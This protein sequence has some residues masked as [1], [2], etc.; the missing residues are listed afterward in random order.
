MY[1]WGF[2]VVSESCLF[3]IK[4]N[5]PVL[6]VQKLFVLALA[7]GGGRGHFFSLVFNFP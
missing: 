5:H 1:T 2:S 3:F 7:I 4:K 6:R